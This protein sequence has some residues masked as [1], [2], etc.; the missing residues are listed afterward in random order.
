M[1]R[2]E[3]SRDG[4]IIAPPTSLVSTTGRCNRDASNVADY[5]VFAARSTRGYLQ[6][7]PVYVDQLT[8]GNSDSVT[9]CD[10]GGLDGDKISDNF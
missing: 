3:K 1:A 5:L 2:Q 4:D 8:G 9:T 10:L 6:E 7:V